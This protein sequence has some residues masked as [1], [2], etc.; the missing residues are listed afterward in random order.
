MK[1]RRKVV[2]VWGNFTKKSID[3]VLEL[4]CD[5]DCKCEVCK[6]AFWIEGEEQK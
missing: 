1:I 5:E 6:D 4:A 3:F 2:C